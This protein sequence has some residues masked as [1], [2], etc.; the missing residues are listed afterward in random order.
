M[1]NRKEIF[2]II[3]VKPYERFK[4]KY[5]PLGNIGDNDYYI[6]GDFEVFEVVDGKS[7]ICDCDNYLSR[8]LAGS[9][10][11]IKYPIIKK[12]FR[13]WNKEDLIEYRKKECFYQKCSTCPFKIVECKP[14]RVECWI[15]HK[16]LY[17]KKFLNQKIK[18]N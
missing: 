8:I 13:Y 7:N 15:N 9:L 12:K 17:S 2:K 5:Y 16:D 11:I 10:E 14:D 1:K 3:G 4:L 6:N 18:N